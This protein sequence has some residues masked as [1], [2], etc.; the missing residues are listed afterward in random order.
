MIRKPARLVRVARIKELNHGAGRVHASGSVYPWPEPK[1]E[2][3]CCHALAVSATGN[4]DQRR[5][6]G[7]ATCARSFK[8]IATIVRF[9]PMSFATSATVPIATTFINAGTCASRPYS[10][11]NA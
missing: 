10:R 9:S 1:P 6:P 11:N 2:I 3:V 4:V 5:K 7:L 8:P